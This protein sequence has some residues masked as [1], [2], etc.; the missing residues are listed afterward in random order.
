MGAVENHLLDMLPTTDRRRLLSATESVNLAMTDVLSEPGEVT[1]Q[2]YFPV[3]CFIS[4]VSLL[5][6]GAGVEVGMIGR[7]GMLGSHLALH[8]QTAPLHSLVQGP[9]TARC[10]TPS[11]FRRELSLSSALQKIVARYIY[12]QIAQ[13][14]TSAACLRFHLVGP[15]LAR[16]LLMSQDRAHADS[17]CLTHEFLAYMLGVRRVGITAAASALQRSGLITYHRGSIT[18]LDRLGLEAA[19]CNCYAVDER[20]YAKLLR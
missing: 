1:R 4:C 5:D 13:M 17:F 14:A 19:A 3:D 7:E 12:V 18:I 16:W 6:K 20:M 2:I 9:G 11:A 8:V 10:M 15:R